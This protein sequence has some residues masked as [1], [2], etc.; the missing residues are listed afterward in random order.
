MNSPDI[1]GKAVADYFHNNDPKNITVISEDFD[2]DEIPT[3]YL[4]RNFEQMP[5]LEQKALELASGKILDVGCCAGSHALY[6]QE[7]GKNVKAID[8][9]PKA[10]EIARLRGIK[11]AEVENFFNLN[12]QLLQDK[13]TRY[14]T[15]NPLKFEGKSLDNKS[16]GGTNEKFDTILMLMNGIGIV[17][18]LK[19]LTEFF[20]HLKTILSANGKVLLDSSDLNYLFDRDEDGGIW[21]NPEEYY[22]ELT[23]QLTYKGETSTP[24]DWLYIDFESLQLAAEMNGFSCSLIQKGEH[25]DYLA[26]LKLS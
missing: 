26:M 17:G 10:I 18:K 19:N 4:F 11:N 23:Y 1:F 7:K 6:L 9:S 20:T 14:S 21:V 24:F 22:G 2:D 16:F 12:N 13:S 3:D 25:Y 5:T 15:E 8:I